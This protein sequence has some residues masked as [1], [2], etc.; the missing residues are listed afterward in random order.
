MTERPKMQVDD[1]IVAYLDPTWNTATLTG[2]VKSIGRVNVKIH[3]RVRFR[4]EGPWYDQE[5][6]VP[7]EAV[8]AI[9]RDGA[10]FW[11]DAFATG[12]GA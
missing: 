12:R 4:P 6:K 8:N 3:T 10:I 9:A 2:T 5:H 7:I 11:R 1:A